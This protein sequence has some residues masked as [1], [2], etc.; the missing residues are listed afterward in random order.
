MNKILTKVG[1][2]LIVGVMVALVG[3]LAGILWKEY[4][5]ST[6]ALVDARKTLERQTGEWNKTQINTNEAQ[7]KINEVVARYM[8]E[9]GG[10][11]E[12]IEK[13]L[14]ELAEAVK[15]IAGGASSDIGVIEIPTTERLLS[16][17]TEDR[18]TPIPI[19]KEL[20]DLKKER[21]KYQDEQFMIQKGF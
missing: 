3:S 9:Q 19:L 15:S 8:D 18:R 10:L 11:N 14:R 21:K 2:G 5:K 17:D 20:E 4:I 7:G 13:T 12:R 16:T 1:E 6:T